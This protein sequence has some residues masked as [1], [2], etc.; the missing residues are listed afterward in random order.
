MPQAAGIIHL[1]ATSCYVTDNADAI[2]LRQALTLIRAKV[3]E[4]LRRLKDFAL[5]YK[6]LPTLGLT[7]LQPAQLV[8]VGKRATLWMQDLV[9][10]LADIDHVM[11]TIRLLGSKGTTGTQASFLDLFGGDGALC[12]RCEALIAQKMG[13][14]KVYPVSGQTYPLCWTAAS[15]LRSAAW[16]QSAYVRP[17]SPAPSPFTSWEEPFGKDQIALPPWPTSATPCARS[18]SAPWP[19]T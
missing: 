7:H 10:D 5:Q 1:G 8:T 15:R 19:A 14:D 2:I 18:A 12:D 9:M 16:A 11:S 17:D 6:D 13:M 3:V 4:V